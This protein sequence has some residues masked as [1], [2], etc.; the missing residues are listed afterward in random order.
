MAPETARNFNAVATP[1][2]TSQV[3]NERI[4]GDA[5]TRDSRIGSDL[6]NHHD[7]V[8]PSRNKTSKP[9]QPKREKKA[10][11]KHTNANS[12]ALSMSPTQMRSEWRK[13]KTPLI[14]TV[15]YR[16]EPNNNKG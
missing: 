7:Q 14:Q 11:K 13:G 16:A 5:A 9:R 15:K 12:H 10:L 4:A 8:Q 6:S 2:R 3:E 1:L